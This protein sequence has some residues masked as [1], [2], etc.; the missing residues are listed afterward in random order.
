M[1]HL[2]PLDLL[3]LR[4]SSQHYGALGARHTVFYMLA[5]NKWSNFGWGGAGSVSLYSSSQLTMCK[6]FDMFIFVEI[7]CC[8]LS[9]CSFFSTRSFTDD[10]F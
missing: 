7:C 6:L 8:V 3:L 9:V 2:H 5:A 4:L 10:K 1:E